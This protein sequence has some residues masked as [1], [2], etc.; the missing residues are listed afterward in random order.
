MPKII[1]PATVYYPYTQFNEFTRTLGLP[2]NATRFPTVTL[3][4]GTKVA[5]HE[6]GHRGFK[7]DLQGFHH[8]SWTPSG[9]AFD[10]TN[11]CPDFDMVSKY[12]PE[13]DDRW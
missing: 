11:E 12:V 1:N 8:I 13:G 6:D 2:L 5:V 4:D 10:D 3:R 7:T 9:H